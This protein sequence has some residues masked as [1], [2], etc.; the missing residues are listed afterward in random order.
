VGNM[1]TS[2]GTTSFSRRTLL[3]GVSEGLEPF[4]EVF[5]DVR[6]RNLV[7]NTH[8]PNYAVGSQN[9]CRFDLICE[10]TNAVGPHRSNASLTTRAAA[11][12]W[13]Y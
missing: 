6:P 5:W 8:P 10:F 1:L 3:H 13:N 12:L 11:F 7:E 2:W 9:K 4:T